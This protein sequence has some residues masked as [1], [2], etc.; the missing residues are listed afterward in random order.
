MSGFML[1]V[2]S[3]TLILGGGFRMYPHHRRAAR[4]PDPIE[5]EARRLAEIEVEELCRLTMGDLEPVK[6]RD[7]FGGL[8]PRVTS[9]QRDGCSYSFSANAR[10][11]APTIQGNYLQSF[12]IGCGEWE[13][14]GDPHIHVYDN[15]GRAVGCAPVP[16]QNRTRYA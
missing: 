6:P 16:L 15:M 8:S 7:T 11:L 9:V 3:L 13:R 2:I 4:E 1:V 10:P 12:C 5:I 14:N